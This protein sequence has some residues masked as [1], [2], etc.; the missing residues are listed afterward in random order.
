MDGF[1]AGMIE[2]ELVHSASVLTFAL[3]FESIRFLLLEA[4]L[5][6]RYAVCLV[7]LMF[8]ATGGCDCDRLPVFLDVVCVV[9]MV[10]GLEMA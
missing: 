5:L 1:F 8:Y 7:A 3:P 10:D 4:I 6:A 9:V 2:D